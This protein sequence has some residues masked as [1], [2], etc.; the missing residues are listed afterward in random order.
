MQGDDAGGQSTA[1]RARDLQPAGRP[2]KVDLGA[3]VP[4]KTLEKLYAQRSRESE[5][6]RKQQESIDRRM[7]DQRI[8]ELLSHDGFEGQRYERFVEEL[9]RYGIAV[10]RAWMHS[11]YIF[12]LVG[13]RGFGL[14]PNELELEELH[15]NDDLREELATMTVACALPRFRRRAFVEGG[16]RFEGGASIT[17]YFMG[18]CIYDFPNE[19]RKWRTSEEKYFR[20]LGRQKAFYEDPVRTVGT[21]EEVLSKLRVLLELEDID[22]PRT[23]AAVAMV[24]DGYSQEEICEVLNARTVRAVEGLLYRW[25]TKIKRQEGRGARG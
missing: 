9:V 10:L 23:K 16:W 3:P 19:F 15:L 14:N 2:D 5:A 4:M 13:G 22:D 6:A 18:A 20:A 12:K 8:V 1:A 21:D 7:A 25:R 24:I 17:T 11:G